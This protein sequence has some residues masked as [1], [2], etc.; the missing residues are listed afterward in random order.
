M[1]ISSALEVNL[2]DRILDKILYV[3]CKSGMPV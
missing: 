2:D 3:V 1:V